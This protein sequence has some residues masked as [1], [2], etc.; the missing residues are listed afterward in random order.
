MDV[1]ALVFYA[2]VCGLLSLAAPASGRPLS[3]IAIGAAVGIAAAA[4]LPALR[5]TFGLP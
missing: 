4:L 2:I 3:R 5:T 1:T